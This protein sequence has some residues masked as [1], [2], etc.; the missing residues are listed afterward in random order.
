LRHQGHNISVVHVPAAKQEQGCERRHQQTRR[1][2]SEKHSRSRDIGRLLGEAPSKLCLYCCSPE[3]QVVE[4]HSGVCGCPGSAAGPR[5]AKRV[6]SSHSV[7]GGGG[8]SP[9]VQHCG[10]ERGQCTAQGVPAR[11]VCR[12]GGAFKAGRVLINL[13]PLPSTQA[14]VAAAEAA[15]AAAAAVLGLSSPGEVDWLLARGI[16]LSQGLGQLQQHAR[17][18]GTSQAQTT[19]TNRA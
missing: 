16:H 17:R 5:R 15:A 18:Q 4:P 19:A 10:V 13:I 11:M 9:S 14:T 2:Q 8:G 7:V 12:G 3:S 6:H 1:E